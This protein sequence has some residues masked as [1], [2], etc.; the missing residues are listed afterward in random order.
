MIKIWEDKWIPN[1]TSPRPVSTHP[2]TKS[3]T[4]VADLM[5]HQRICWKKSI[6]EQLFRPAEVAQIM[7]LPVH[8][9]GTRDKLFWGADRKGLFTVKSAYQLAISMKKESQ[10]KV[11]SSRAGLE[12]MKMWRAVWKLPLKP[13]LKHFL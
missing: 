4:R 8:P 10:T 3:Y 11:E 2:E 9:Y 1:S 12:R 7:Q 13:K 5:D 6:L